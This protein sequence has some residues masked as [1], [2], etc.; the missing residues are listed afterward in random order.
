MIL[1]YILSKMAKTAF[2][3]IWTILLLQFNGFSQITFLGDRNQSIA[4][5]NIKYFAQKGDSIFFI[6]NPINLQGESVDELWLTDGT[7]AGTKNVVPD[8]ATTL[9]LPDLEYIALNEIAILNGEVFIASTLGL[10]KSDG[11]AAG[12]VLLK[13]VGNINGFTA[14]NGLLFFSAND[15]VHGEELWKSDGTVA[16]TQMVKDINLEFIENTNSSPARFHVL[17]NLVIFDAFTHEFGRELWKSDGT[18]AGTQMIKDINSGSADLQTYGNGIVDGTFLYLDINDGTNGN[19]LWRTDGTTIATELVKDINAGSAASNPKHFILFNGS[20]YF[21]ASGLWKTDG[22][23]AGTSMVKNPGA[24]NGYAVYNGS[25]YF[26]A[27]NY[28]WKSNG[29]LAGTTGLA[30]MSGNSNQTTFLGVLNNKLYLSCNSS[31]LHGFEIY[32]CN[33]SSLTRV[34][35]IWEGE[36]DGI[37]DGFDGPNFINTGSLIFFEGNDG[38]GSTLWKTD[39]QLSGTLKVKDI[40]QSG[41][42]LTYGSPAYIANMG[43]EVIFSV[44]NTGGELWKSDGTLAGT[45]QLVDFTPSSTM[46]SS[47]ISGGG[48]AYMYGDGAY[49]VSDGTIAGSNEVT[50]TNGW[51][52]T[53]LD[54]AIHKASGKLIFASGSW[55]SGTTVTNTGVEP[56]VSDGTPSGTFRLKDLLPGGGIPGS[57]DPEY[58]TATDTLL[59]FSAKIDGNGSKGLIKTDGTTSGTLVVTGAPE[60]RNEAGGYIGNTVVY[61]GYTGG[62]GNAVSGVFK[63]DGSTAGSMLIKSFTSCNNF[64]SFDSLVAFR[65][66]SDQRGLWI[67][68]G[69]ESGTV[70]LTT[71]YSRVYK[72]FIKLNSLIYF[73]GDEYLYE[74]DGTL[75]G[76]EVI[77]TGAN[78]IVR[79]DNKIYLISDE[80]FFIFDGDVSTMVEVPGSD[81]LSD[82]HSAV[83]NGDNLFFHATDY[84]TGD[85]LY[86]YSIPTDPVIAIR[87]QFATDVKYIKPGETLAGI[88]GT[89]GRNIG[90]AGLDETITGEYEYVISNSGG[91][92]LVIDP[93]SG[94]GGTYGSHFDFIDLPT[95]IAPGTVAIF[96]VTFTGNVQYGNQIAQLSI[97]SNDPSVPSYTFEVIGNSNSEPNI[98]FYNSDFSNPNISTLDFGS[99]LIGSAKADTMYLWNDGYGNPLVIDSLVFSG[100]AF[101][102]YSV[103]ASNPSVLASRYYTIPTSSILDSV[104]NAPDYHSLLEITF[105]PSANGNRKGILNIY[106]ND[107]ENPHIIFSLSGKGVCQE[108]DPISPAN[109]ADICL[110]TEDSVILSIPP[111]PN[112]TYCWGSFANWTTVGTADYHSEITKVSDLKFDSNNNPMVAFMSSSKAVSVMKYENETW[113]LIG[114][115]GFATGYKTSELDLVIDDNDSLFVSYLNNYKK[116][117]VMKFD[118]TNWVQ[119]GSNGFSDGVAQYLSMVIANDTIYV[120][121]QD[122]G[123]F[124]RGIVKKWDGTQWLALSGNGISQATAHYLDMETRNDSIFVAL[125]DGS[126][127]N[128]GASLYK[129]TGSNWEA[130][131]TKG[132]SDGEASAIN[133]EFDSNGIP[134]VAYGD[135]EQIGKA[136]VMKYENGLWQ[137]IGQKGLPFSGSANYIEAKFMLNGTVAYYSFRYQYTIFVYTFNGTDWEPI[138][139][140]SLPSNVNSNGI[141]SHDLAMDNQGK[142]HVFYENK[143]NHNLKYYNAEADCLGTENTFTTANPGFY[144]VL[145]TDLNTNCTT[146]SPNT[147]EVKVTDCKP[148]LMVYGNDLLISSGDNSP[149]T[150]DF[151]IIGYNAKDDTISKEFVLYNSGEL[152]VVIVDSVFLTGTD[153]SEFFIAVQPNVSILPGDSIPFTVSYSAASYKTSNAGIRIVS[154]DPNTPEYTFAIRAETSGITLILED[155]LIVDANNNNMWDPGDT[156][157]YNVIVKNAADAP[158][159]SNVQVIVQLIT[160]NCTHVGTTISQLGT[161]LE[162]AN[163][164]GALYASLTAGAVDTIV[165]LAL[166]IEASLGDATKVVNQAFVFVGNKP[167]ISSDDPDLPGKADPTETLITPSCTNPTAA[168]EIGNAQSICSGATPSTITSVSVP[169]G[170]Y[171]TLEYKWQVSTTSNSAGFSDIASSNAETYT[172][173]ALT[174]S[175]WYKRLARVDCVTDWSGAVESNVVEIT[176]LTVAVPVLSIQSNTATTS[177]E[178]TVNGTI[179][180]VCINATNRGAIWYEYTD[181]DLEI[182]D[183]DVTNV[184]ESGDF[185][186][187]AFT[188]ALTSLSPNTRYN[189]RAHATNPDGIAYSSRTDFRTLANIPAAP[190]VDGATATSLDVTVNVNSNPTSTEFCINET[191]TGKFVQ[192]DGSLNT[193]EVWQTATVWGSKT[194]TA[195]TTGTTY[196]FKVKARN[197]YNI[198]TTYSDEAQG[199]PVAVPNVTTQTT[200]TIANTTATGNGTITNTNGSNATNRGLIVYPYT[201]SDKGI[202]DGGVI[203]ADESGDFIAEAFTALFTGLD[204]N[205]R[206]NTRAHAANQYGTGYGNRESFWTLAN[207]PAAPTVDGAIATSLDV[208]VNENSNPASTE[209]CIYETSNAKFVQANGTLNTSEVWQTA[210]AWG[211]ITLNG[212]STGVTYTFKVKARNGDNVETAYGSEASATTCQNPGNGGTIAAAQTICYGTTPNSLSS[213]SE[214]SGFGG[215]LE[216][217]WQQ[218]TT[219]AASGFSDISS[220]NSSTLTPGS[221]N[222]STWY[223]RLARVDC[224]SDWANAA[225]SNVVEITIEELAI[226]GTLA[227]TPNAANVCDGENVSATLTAGSGGNGV[228]E[229]ESR[230]NDG[231]SW[232]SWTTYTSGNNISTTGK[233]NVEIRTRRTADYCNHASYTTLS[234]GVWA[235]PE[236]TCPSNQLVCIDGAPI[237]LTLLGATPALGTFSGTSVSNSNFYPA[238]SGA[239]N[240]PINYSYTDANGCTDDCVFDITVS[241]LAFV[242]AGVDASICET[243]YQLNPTVNYEDIITW[244]S[245][246]DGTF[247]D[248]YIEGAYYT[249][250]PGDLAAGSVILE[251]VATPVNDPPCINLTSDQ[252]TLAIM[253]ALPTVSI[254]NDVTICESD[255]YTFAPVV[256]NSQAV[257]WTTFGDGSFDNKYIEGATYTP[258]TG[259]IAAGFIHI[260]LDAAPFSPCV[261]II[262]DDMFIYLTPEPSVTPGN[263]ATICETGSHTITGFSV[264]DYSSLSWTGGDGTFDDA[265]LLNAT[266][267]PGPA[268]KSSG[269]VQLCLTANSIAPCT[270][271]DQACMTLTFQN[272]PMAIAGCAGFPAKVC[273]GRSIQLCG[274]GLYYSSSEWLGGVGTF[275]SRTADN[276]TYTPA[277]SEYGDTITFTLVVYPESP[278]AMP[279]S[280]ITYLIVQENPTADAGDNTSICYSETYTLG[281]ASATDYS[282]VSWATNGGGTFDNSA[283]LNPIYTPSQSDISA[284]SVDLTLTVSAT[285]PCTQQATSTMTLTIHPEPAVIFH[286]NSNP[287][288][289]GATMYYCADDNITVSLGQVLSGTGPFAIEWTENG[290]AQGPVTVNLNDNLFSGTKAAGTYDIQ[291]TK[292]A[293]IYG[294]EPADYT[295]YNASFVVKPMPTITSV[296]PSSAE[297]CDG[298]AVSFSASGLLDGTTLFSYTIDDGVNPAFTGTETVTVAGGMYTF[299]AAVYPVGTYTIYINSIEVDG[300]TSQF[301]NTVMTSFTVHPL[302]VVTCP[303]SQDVC[304]D[305]TSLDLSLLGATPAGGTFSGTSVSG[306]IFDPSTAGIGAH[307]ISYS[308]TDGNGCTNDCDF[309]ITVHALPVVVCPPNQEICVDAAPLDLTT[310]G[311]TPAAG[312]FSG[313]F[314]SNDTFDPASAGAGIHSVTYTYTDGFGCENSCTFN[315]TVNDLP[316]AGIS[317]NAAICLGDDLDLD[318]MPTGMMSYNWTG[319]N[320]WTSNSETNTITPATTDYVGDLYYLTVTDANGCSGTASLDVLVGDPQLDLSTDPPLTIVNDEVIVMY[321]VGMDI[322]ANVPNQINPSFSWSNNEVTP[323]INV[324]DFGPYSVTV[325]DMGCEVTGSLTVN[326]KQD[327][328]LRQGWGILST[329]INTA[330]SFDVLLADLVAGNNIVV[331]DEDGHAFISYNG[332][333]SN[334]LTLG[335]IMGKGYQYYMSTPNQVLTVVGSAIDPGVTTLSLDSGYNFIGYLRR[336]S[337]PVAQLMAPIASVIDIMKDE[338][339][340]VYWYVP[341]LGIWINQIG[342]L[343]PGKGYQL[344]LLADAS[345]TY[346]ANTVPFSKSDIY[347]AKPSYFAAPVSTGSNMTLGIPEKAWNIAVNVGDE[348]GVFNQNGDLVGSGV[349]DNDNMAISLWGDNETTK[350]TNGL[351]NKE[352]YTLQLWNSLSGL[353]ETLVVTE[354][355]EG[356]GTYGENDIAIVGKL[357]IVEESGLSLSNYPNPFKDVTTI[358]FSI[359]EDGKVRVELFNSNGKRLQVI[360]DRDYT[361]GTHEVQFSATKLA[362][363]TYFIKLESNGQTLNKAV[364]IVK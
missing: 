41:I 298:E 35:D 345:F 90:S 143:G 206:Y 342:D 215:T 121:Y 324:T 28:L 24:V 357:A 32:E 284:G 86:S 187:T 91:S 105:S 283:S 57:S 352:A 38:S 248:P 125:Q 204:V 213:I 29:T 278:C 139:Q 334:G 112:A 2:I 244:T 200:S 144:N 227:K 17:G 255:A 68:D 219:D 45:N 142:L 80:R 208:T 313:T 61:Y 83:V 162:N 333:Y 23:L 95:T 295:P 163:V 116:P 155:T 193:T 265:S 136:T 171:G 152:P 101:A 8:F 160:G 312:S 18:E 192:A 100:A 74:S 120:A 253:Q 229:L 315:I 114:A 271:A 147:V 55:L 145:V 272:E 53:S 81:D 336:T 329:Y 153:A 241:P 264:T 349:Y 179:T 170:E 37:T 49:W 30:P 178:S 224:K 232:S 249:P 110:G 286:E 321:P 309:T 285:N 63:S 161:P 77:F 328:L 135:A 20:I 207:V 104:K 12:T 96:K 7:E 138:G 246:G 188:A 177:T 46:P 262:N 358:E 89:T 118:G 301:G 294:C 256:A 66:V 130:V 36:N 26:V 159:Y 239:G 348:V 10:L 210:V 150:N 221:L 267:T 164:F 359:P 34:S 235:L 85:E 282:S 176:V 341:S 56:W 87:A 273:A 127:A 240:H 237:D 303:P 314:V 268:D 360:T 5:A 117:A 226:S 274:T 252:I 137:L 290:N 107:P 353:I 296:D 102:D 299:A 109:P 269:S 304:I 211:T 99:S 126:V 346:P 44:Q 75:A 201:D 79:F 212:L 98:R 165:G 70:Q 51:V 42:I 6:S 245:Y 39:G 307:T 310:L 190:T 115:A 259:D 202:G 297:I 311:A 198:G 47:I 287:F 173:G 59:Y 154:N 355:I 131:G 217:K 124:Y 113:S 158:A 243:G 322:W 149:R 214:A 230:T 146:Q 236:V 247:D 203:N 140:E 172:P 220:S 351:A 122:E 93:S 133:L 48:K 132:F 231:T 288:Y 338:D 134:Y 69:T 250:G 169:S 195:L 326:E 306:D 344:K 76:T 123:I 31:S 16:G 327:I 111:V 58:F 181:S 308:F 50:I 54:G 175:T 276:P 318:A 196:T 354:W 157:Q 305:L 148:E 361:A 166:P 233:T 216:Y 291:I 11:S 92:A 242:D 356:N 156:I 279:D 1:N 330:A 209:F 263:D 319:P 119:L 228:D 33:G 343:W 71:N 280:N 364:Q 151:T 254:G 189:V 225:E 4:D 128:G 82:F 199:V 191:S 292:I 197:G 251:L 257:L 19:E 72:D 129:Y 362:V 261:N 97:L 84:A 22:T 222:V 14:T 350:Q 183:T 347:V 289:S 167:T 302:P 266:Y 275:S 67:T 270:G 323:Y 78:Q 108:I 184:D 64:N 65:S 317:S 52:G 13:S 40:S 141:A 337:A 168:G 238:T 94:F 205:T 21:T 62:V 88:S 185:G 320:G 3:L 73:I 325:T 340:K 335:Y 277:A 27:D 234:W 363:G 293:D 186:E 15:S 180:Q 103:S 218:S 9:G 60:I 106:T 174:A 339:G 194:V 300:C 25:L 260:K 332:A 331:K 258:G 281:D 316:V 43:S 223:K 182:G